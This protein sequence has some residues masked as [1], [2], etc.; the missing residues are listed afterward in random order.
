MQRYKYG[1]WELPDNALALLKPYGFVTH[2]RVAE[3]DAGNAGKARRDYFRLKPG[4]AALA[5]LR[6][7]VEQIAWDDAQTGAIGLLGV[8]SAKRPGRR[9]R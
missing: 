8:A 5:D 7:S 2:R 1:A 9:G 4:E 6:A 3:I